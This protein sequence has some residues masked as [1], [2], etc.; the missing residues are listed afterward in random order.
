MIIRRVGVFSA[1]KV[2]CLLYMFIGLI[3]GAFVALLWVWGSAGSLSSGD[4]AGSGGA[5]GALLGTGVIAIVIFPLVY[6]VMGAIGGAIMGFFY[7]IVASMVGGI[8]LEVDGPEETGE[9]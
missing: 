5:M 4:P 8:E 2:L 6:W 7:N 3:A 1:V 9:V